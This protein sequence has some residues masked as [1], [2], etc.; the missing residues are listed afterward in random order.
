M[1]FLLALLALSGAGVAS[2][3]PNYTEHMFMQVTDHF[4]ILS[5]GTFK[6]RY[7]RTGE[8]QSTFYVSV[9]VRMCVCVCM[10]AHVR[11]L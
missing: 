3:V 8:Q 6:Q 4:D 2:S 10:H 1:I 7:L 11:I 5:N 9:G